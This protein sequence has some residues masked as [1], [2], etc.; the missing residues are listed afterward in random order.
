VLVFETLVLVCKAL[1]A[2]QVFAHL[3]CQSK[4]IVLVFKP[5]SA[6]IQNPL[7]GILS[8]CAGNQSFGN[9]NPCTVIQNPCADIQNH[10]TGILRVNAWFNPSS[11]PV[12]KRRGFLPRRR[13]GRCSVDMKVKSKKYYNLKHFVDFFT[14]NYL[15]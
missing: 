4:P 10:R 14:L 15:L 3:N 12:C 9:Q 5:H 7:A 1:Y 11:V 13:G 8:L 2:L 6:G